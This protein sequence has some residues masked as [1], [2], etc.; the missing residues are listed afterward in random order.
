LSALRVAGLWRA[1]WRAVLAAR[2]RAAWWCRSAIR[3]AGRRGSGNRAVF[4]L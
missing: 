1:A 2:S 3:G 4:R